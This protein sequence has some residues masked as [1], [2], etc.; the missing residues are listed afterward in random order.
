MC[1]SSLF[2]VGGGGGPWKFFF[3]GG[4]GLGKKRRNMGVSSPHT[5][6]I[7]QE[8]ESLRPVDSFPSINPVNSFFVEDLHD[9]HLFDV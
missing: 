3:V 6:K 4:G 2:F 1:A 7:P 5:R 8:G 9:S